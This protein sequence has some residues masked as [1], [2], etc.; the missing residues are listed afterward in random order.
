M[1]TDNPDKI[2]ELLRKKGEKVTPA[3]MAILEVLSDC[4][5]LLSVAEIYDRLREQNIKMNYSTVYRNLEVLCRNK[6]TEKI[7]FPDGAKFK[8]FDEGKHTHHLICKSCHR[9]EIL[10]YCPF[11]DVKKI[12][13]S[14]TN[15]LPLE[16][17]L[18]IYGYCEK[19]QK[20]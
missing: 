12:I 3:R 2:S 19:C 8:L 11:E 15:F 18:E 5:C 17:K 20:K 1:K 14:N 4:S 6:I 13:K 7:A 16:H 10:S 9:T